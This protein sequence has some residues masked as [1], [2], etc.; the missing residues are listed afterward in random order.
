MKP[1]VFQQIKALNNF[2]FYND[3]NAFKLLE[4]L[5]PQGDDD[6]LGTFYNGENILEDL[7]SSYN[8][9]KSSMLNQW[10]FLKYKDEPYD[11]VN[12][13]FDKA[14]NNNIIVHTLLIETIEKTLRVLTM[15]ITMTTLPITYM[16]L[17]E[18][19]MV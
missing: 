2:I 1:Q 18:M 7:F 13:I 11:F 16:T 10:Y 17:Y 12:R 14:P 8:Y 4:N 6:G 3:V 19:K 9:Y 15:T 5:H